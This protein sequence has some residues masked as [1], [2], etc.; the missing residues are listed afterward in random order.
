MGGCLSLPRIHPLGGGSSDLNGSTFSHYSL[1]SETSFLD[2]YPTIRYVESDSSEWRRSSAPLLEE[3]EDEED[4]EDDEVFTKSDKTMTKNPYKDNINTATNTTTSS[5]SN[6]ETK[7]LLLK[8]D[9]DEVVVVRE[10]E[11]SSS[12]HSLSSS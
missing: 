11:S 2:L 5:S 8:V 9:E 4:Y 1:T 3:D 10:A 12:S 7:D 6:N